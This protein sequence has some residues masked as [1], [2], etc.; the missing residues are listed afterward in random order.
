MPLLDLIVAIKNPSTVPATVNRDLK[1]K[2]TM[3]QISSLQIIL[4]IYKHFACGKTPEHYVNTI[5]G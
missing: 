3:S 5:T 2:N 4:T 1:N